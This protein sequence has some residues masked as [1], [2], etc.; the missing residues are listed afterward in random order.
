MTA[1]T[2][3]PQLKAF[4]RNDITV[5]K[6]VQRPQT[7]GARRI[8]QNY[9]VNKE[10]HLSAGYYTAKDGDYFW[11]WTSASWVPC[12]PG[13]TYLHVFDGQHRCSARWQDGLP[14]NDPSHRFNVVIEYPPVGR[15][16]TKG[17][18]ADKFTAYNKD[19]TKTNAGNVHLM[20]LAREDDA[21]LDIQEVADEFGLTIAGS[22]DDKG[23]PGFQV[24]SV[25][26][27]NTIYNKGRTLGG[28]QRSQGKALLKAVLNLAFR[29]YDQPFL[30]NEAEATNTPYSTLA[31][32]RLK[33]DLLGGFA[34]LIADNAAIHQYLLDRNNDPERYD[35]VVARFQKVRLREWGNHASKVSNLNTGE[36]GRAKLYAAA[37]VDF[38]KKDRSLGKWKRPG[39]QRASR[40]RA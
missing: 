31:N 35:A 1:T 28:D 27:L 21:A 5:I 10:G 24:Q 23:K 13:K 30:A 2:K 38:L 34:N 16:F 6:G 39:A 19:R 8:S 17:Q 33:G 32:A 36:T 14:A 7:D 9:D 18:L 12:V 26:T 3:V 29:I 40:V 4:G 20:D 37:M 22:D 11:D 15:V 25:K